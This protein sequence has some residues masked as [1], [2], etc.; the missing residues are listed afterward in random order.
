MLLHVG[1]Y[2]S[3]VHNRQGFSHRMWPIYAVQYVCMHVSE[4][5]FW[6]WPGL[7]AMKDDEWL[8]LLYLFTSYGVLCM[9]FCIHIQ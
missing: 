3:F 9:S 6:L 5:V 7:M 2:P 8:I 4:C 1:L